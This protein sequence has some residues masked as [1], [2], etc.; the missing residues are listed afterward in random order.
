MEDDVK[1]IMAVSLLA[2]CTT[3]G[4]AAADDSSA[5]AGEV[6]PASQTEAQPETGAPMNVISTGSYGKLAEDIE[7]GRR[8]APFIEV[9]RTPD[10]LDSLWNQYIAEGEQPSVDFDQSIVVFLLM[11]PQSTG[12]Y[13]IEPKGAKLVAGTLEVDATLHQ[14]GQGDMVTQAFTA[15]YAVLEVGGLDEP[16]DK[17]VWMNEGRPLATRMLE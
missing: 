12:G 14:P 5:V 17:V 11:P 15:P 1:T 8:R 3:V 6:P 16:V 7:S 2:I 4:C 9:A 10:E 13:G